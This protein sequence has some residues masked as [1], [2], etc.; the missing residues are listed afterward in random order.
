MKTDCEMMTKAPRMVEMEREDV[1]PLAYK[2][3]LH[4]YSVSFPNKVN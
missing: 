2:V 4:F 1:K 3:E